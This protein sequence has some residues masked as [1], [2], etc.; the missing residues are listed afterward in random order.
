M[1]SIEAALRELAGR[2]NID[3]RHPVTEENW[4]TWIYKADSALAKKAHTE[5]LP[6]TNEQIEICARLFRRPLSLVTGPAGTGKTTVI[7]A[8]I[9]AVR[10]TEGEGAH[11]LVLAPT[12][13]AADR[14]RE[15]FDR[16]ALKGV[17]TLTVHSFLASGG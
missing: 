6:A 13:K 7:E 14:A 1:V 3:L 8:L 12:G 9:R 2:P 17:A 15:L 4:K 11:I 16:A 5:Y 10:R